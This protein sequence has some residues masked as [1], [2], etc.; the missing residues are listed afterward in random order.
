M[1]LYPK[2][3]PVR[4]KLVVGEEEHSSLESLRDN[5]DVED[6]IRLYENGGLRNWLR[7]INEE[8]I[9]IQLDEEKN[10]DTLQ[11]YKEVFDLFF[12]DKILP[13]RERLFHLQNKHYKSFQNL[14][15]LLIKNEKFTLPV[16]GALMLKRKSAELGDSEFCKNISEWFYKLIEKKWLNIFS[17]YQAKDKGNNNYEF[18]TAMELFA[19]QWNVEKRSGCDSQSD[20]ILEDAKRIINVINAS[21]LLKECGYKLQNPFDKFD[22]KYNLTS[23]ERNIFCEKRDILKRTIEGIIKGYFSVT[24]LF[25]LKIDLHNNS[26]S[27]SFYADNWYDIKS[28]ISEIT[29]ESYSRKLISWKW[30]IIRMFMIGLMRDDISYLKISPY[31]RLNEKFYQVKTFFY[32]HGGTEKLKDAQEIIYRIIGGSV[33]KNRK[34][35]DRLLFQSLLF[36]GVMVLYKDKKSIDDLLHTGYRPAML[37]FGNAKPVNDLEKEFVSLDEIGEKIHFLIKNIFEI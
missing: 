1:K 32:R 15:K 14:F 18:H 22:I 9:W 20:L 29:R 33:L 35:A 4:I 5:F 8:N 7:Q 16:E 3:R 21:E 13:L 24:S 19:H 12:P 31:S 11:K 10:L 25:E 34:G 17:L 27:F 30:A 37:L 2:A 28:T 36:I 23:D 26:D 6:I